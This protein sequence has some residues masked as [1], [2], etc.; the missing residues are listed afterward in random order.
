MGDW[1]IGEIRGFSMNY[2]PEGWHLCDGTL[3][4]VQQNQALFS[5]LRNYYGGDGT[6]NF[7]LPDLRGRVIAGLNLAAKDYQYGKT[8]G[9]E[10]VALTTA[11]MPPHNHNVMV[12]K[13]AGTFV[14]PTG[15][16][17]SACGT[18]TSIPTALNL[19]GAPGATP[20]PLNAKSLS[21]DGVGVAHDNMQPYQVLTYCIATTGVYPPRN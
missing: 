9:A 7:A 16:Y 12:V 21:V 4:L 17:I 13:E 18:N 11:A 5:L 6:N 10:T 15:N 19:F 8:G 14:L 3:L 1:F 2:A 20:L